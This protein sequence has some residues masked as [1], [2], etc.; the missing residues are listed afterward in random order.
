MNWIHL[1]EHTNFDSVTINYSPIP[2]EKI[3]EIT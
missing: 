2:F 1:Y 3:E